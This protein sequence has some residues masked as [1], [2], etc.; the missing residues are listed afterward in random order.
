MDLRLNRY[1]LH[2]MY[3]YTYVYTY[4]VQYVCKPLHRLTFFLLFVGYGYVITDSR[5]SLFYSSEVLLQISF[6]GHLKYKD[7]LQCTEERKMK[8]WQL[9]LSIYK[10]KCIILT[11]NYLPFTNES[12]WRVTK[13]SEMTWNLWLVHTKLSWHCGNRPL[14]MH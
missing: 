14:P 10:Q 7:T 1:A 13:T 12:D 9:P 6:V 4:S 3:V 8:S 11:Q 5:C 2:I